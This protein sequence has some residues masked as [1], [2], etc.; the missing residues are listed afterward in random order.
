MKMKLLICC[1]NLKYLIFWLFTVFLAIVS[2]L[3]HELEN[4]HQP[5]EVELYWLGYTYLPAEF[6]I[7][8]GPFPRKPESWHKKKIKL[9]SHLKK[10]TNLT[11]IS[12]IILRYKR[13]ITPFNCIL[14][15]CCCSLFPWFLFLLTV[16]WSE[17]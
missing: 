3:K 17:A 14:N 5:K 11:Y 1:L 8:R 2:F 16:V 9:Y 10:S 13:M 15:S 6:W 7:T 12:N 4:M